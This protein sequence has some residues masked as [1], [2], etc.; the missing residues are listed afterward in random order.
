MD[1]NA[2]STAW[3]NAITNRRGRILEEFLISNQLNIT[4]E[5]SALTTFEPARGTSNVDLT[6][7]N[8]TMIKL[9]Y[10]WSAL[11]RKAFLTTGTLFWHC[12]T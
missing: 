10:T 1:S 2:R 8:S 6:I 12:K 11:T 4:N 9:L 3:Y 5:N 7:A